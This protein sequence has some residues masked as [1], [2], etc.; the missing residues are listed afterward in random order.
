MSRNLKASVSGPCRVARFYMAASDASVTVTPRSYQCLRLVREIL[1]QY[2]EFDECAADVRVG[3]VTH[4]T[5][6]HSFQDA[7]KAELVRHMS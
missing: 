1:R 5:R 2:T 4:L 7:R 6:S 3:V